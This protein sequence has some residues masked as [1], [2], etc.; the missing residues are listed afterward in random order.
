MEGMRTT[1][2]NRESPSP[3]WPTRATPEDIITA[4]VNWPL[5]DGDLFSWLACLL[6][7]G[8]MVLVWGVSGDGLITILSGISLAV[9]LWRTYLPVRWEIGLSGITQVVLGYKRRIPWIAIAKYE[10]QDDGVWLFADRSA[11]SL[12][13]VFIAYGEN[14]EVILSWIE[15]YLGAWTSSGDTTTAALANQSPLPAQNPTAST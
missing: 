1:P 7:I 4:V 10:K 12:R 15:Y 9:A 3:M 2:S 13:G 6:A 5:R 11:S 8:C 14:K